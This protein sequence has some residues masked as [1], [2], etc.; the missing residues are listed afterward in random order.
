[1]SKTTFEKWEFSCVNYETD[2]HDNVTKIWC[3]ICCKFYS[4]QD[5]SSQKKGVAKKSANLLVKGTTTIKKYNAI[6]HIKKLLV[7][8]TAVLCL[9]EK[10]QCEKQ[11][12]AVYFT[13]QLSWRPHIQHLNQVEKTQLT[14]KFQTAHHIVTKAKAFNCY[15]ELVRFN[16]NVMGVN[17]GKPYL[18]RKTWAEIALYLSRSIML[19]KVTEAI[20]GS[21]IWYYNILNDGSSSVKTMNENE[22]FFVKSAP[23]RVPNFAVLSVEEVVGVD[24]KGLKAALDHS[25][26]KVGITINRS[27]KGIGM[28]PGGA[29]VNI[30][31]QQVVKNRL[32]TSICW[33]YALIIKSSL[34][35]V[36]LLIY[37]I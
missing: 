10:K 2:S 22:L 33:F 34:Q 9:T 26:E 36:V 16:K 5:A 37:L 35:S 15:E 21:E 19:E 1:M 29:R 11:T 3:K 6:D 27:D 8:Q 14:K 24:Y 20:N 25:M 13:K 30:T 12:T 18:T 7:H 17:L 4:D 32:A 31:M 23:T 28:C